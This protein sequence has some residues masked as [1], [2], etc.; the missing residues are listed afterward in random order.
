VSETHRFP[1]PESPSPRPW[2]APEGWYP[3]QEQPGTL[4]Y[5]DGSGWTEHQA[6]YA[7]QAPVPWDRPS[8]TYAW[9]LAVTPVMFLL[10]DLT[11]LRLFAGDSVLSSSAVSMGLLV[12]LVLADS[13]KLQRAG[14]RVSP[15]WGVLLLP[16]YLI[17][18]TKRAGSTVA[19]PVV[20]FALMV[21]YV[22]AST[23]MPYGDDRDASET[24]SPAA[25]P[26]PAPFSPT[27]SV[28]Q[29]GGAG[30]WIE[31]FV[32][33]PY[34]DKF[35]YVGHNL[36]PLWRAGYSDCSETTVHG[37]PGPRERKALRTAYPGQ[38]VD[39]ED[40]APLYATCAEN[41]EHWPAGLRA[42]TAVEARDML[43]GVLV[44][45]PKHPQ[46]DKAEHL[47]ANLEVGGSPA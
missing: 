18:R 34:G 44:L 10:T 22:L 38:S 46:R 36:A 9:L 14:V 29:I 33:T 16:V 21:G 8:M 1:D 30:V 3:D 17:L 42:E 20:W 26:S 15:W 45:C 39:V 31:C 7:G 28:R 5:W 32:V 4:R 41:D 13:S 25:V 6:P 27:A 24:A 2:V 40:L 19:V 12:G 47:I 35:D 11:F 37:N 23:A 43:R